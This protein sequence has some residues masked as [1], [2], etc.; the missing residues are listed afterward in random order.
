MQRE[1]ES[2][3]LDKVGCLY[4]ISTSA[5]ARNYKKTPVF[6]LGRSAQNS[7]LYV[8]VLFGIRLFRLRRSG[9]GSI[10]MRI[11]QGSRGKVTVTAPI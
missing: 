1:V 7:I 4:C 6:S 2:M 8:F 9:F 3:Q 5:P 11:I 10:S